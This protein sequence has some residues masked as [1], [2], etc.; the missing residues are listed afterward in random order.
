MLERIL[1]EFTKHQ[2]P[3]SLSLLSQSLQVE[4]AVLEGMLSTLERKG[5]IV[6]LDTG[7]QK[8]VYW[9]HSCPLLEKCPP[10]QKWYRLV[11]AG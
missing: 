2:S 1:G 6:A 5:R 10:E 4:P 8:Q 11:R 9:C 3:L 7:T